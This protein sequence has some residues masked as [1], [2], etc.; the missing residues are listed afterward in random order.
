MLYKSVWMILRNYSG[1]K[2]RQQLSESNHSKTPGSWFFPFVIFYFPFFT[3]SSCPLPTSDH[4]PRSR[5]SWDPQDADCRTLVSPLDSPLSL[6]HIF[7]HS[8]ASGP[9]VHSFHHW[10]WPWQLPYKTRLSFF[11][12]KYLVTSLYEMH[13]VFLLN[14]LNFLLS[15]QAQLAERFY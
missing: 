11:C 2:I 7:I 8:N 3:G 12:D 14:S 6:P 4:R 15:I 9:R 1:I 5:C 13:K 10:S